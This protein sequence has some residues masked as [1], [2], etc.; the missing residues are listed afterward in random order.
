MTPE[1]IEVIVNENELAKDLIQRQNIMIE[2]LM[3]KIKLKDQALNEF[4]GMVLD[5]GYGHILRKGSS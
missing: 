5:Q 2:D 4:F 3:T 1:E